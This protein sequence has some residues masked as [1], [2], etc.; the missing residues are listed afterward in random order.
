MKYVINFLLPENKETEKLNSIRKKYD[1]SYREIWPH[2]TLV[3]PFGKVDGSEIREHINKVIK[4]FEPFEVSFKKTGKSAKENYLYLLV[5]KGKKKIL[6]LHEKLHTG[7]L[8]NHHNPEMPNYI[9]HIT[10]GVFDS[11]ED[12]NEAIKSLQKKKLN[13]R[14][15]FDRIHLMEFDDNNSL[16]KIEEFY[17]G[18]KDE[19]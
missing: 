9:P 10:L 17:L 15:F 11:K 19:H 3:Y 1:P 14:F 4:N 8:K 6:K 5:N 2:M 18:G 13:F 16:N 7:P 12:I